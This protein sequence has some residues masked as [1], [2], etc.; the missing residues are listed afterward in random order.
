MERVSRTL[1]TQEILFLVHTIPRR[2]CTR[3]CFKAFQFSYDLLAGLKFKP[4][5]D[6]STT[7]FTCGDA[8]QTWSRRHRAVVTTLDT[9]S[10]ANQC[11]S[12]QVVLTINGN[13]SSY[14]VLTS[15]NCTKSHSSKLR[16]PHGQWCPPGH[17]PRTSANQ[18]KTDTET[19]NMARA[20]KCEELE[21]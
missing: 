14:I 19:A 4:L 8:S 18:S 15:D 3:G 16:R 21:M 7:Y 6:R 5:F 2:R 17:T 20:V 11:Y 1:V 12:A 9:G 13:F 10:S